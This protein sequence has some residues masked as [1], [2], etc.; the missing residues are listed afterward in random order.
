MFA[1][2]EGQLAFDENCEYKCW[3]DSV[4]LRRKARRR[5]L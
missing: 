3:K 1:L 4:V 5:G 2:K